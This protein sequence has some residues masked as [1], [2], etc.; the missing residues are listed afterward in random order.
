ML[1]KPSQRPLKYP[2]LPEKD[3]ASVIISGRAGEAIKSLEAKGITCIKSGDNPF[4]SPLISSHADMNYCNYSEGVLYKFFDNTAGEWSREFNIF[5]LT[6]P[7][8]NSYPY[9]VTLNSVRIGNKIICNKKTVAPEILDRAFKDGL[10]LI[11]SKQGY[12][13]CSVCVLNENAIITDDVSIYNAAAP[14]FV[15]VTLISKGSVLLPG[16]DYG[17]IGGCTGLI[18]KDKLAFNG[19][20]LSHSDHNKIIDALT[21]NCVNAIELSVNRL[22]DIGSILPLTEKI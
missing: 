3:V 22:E 5:S 12:S 1:M 16:Y 14:Y 18:G 6:P 19:Q 7:K 17:L 20:I 8:N 21:A 13:K 11:D 9:D 2:N 4:L 10:I 15:S